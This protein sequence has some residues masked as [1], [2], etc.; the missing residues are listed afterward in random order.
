MLVWAWPSVTIKCTEASNTEKLPYKNLTRFLSVVSGGWVIS[1][2]IWNNKHFLPLKWQSHAGHWYE[3]KCT[4]CWNCMHPRNLFIVL[5]PPA[6]GFRTLTGSVKSALDL[7]SPHFSRVCQ[8]QDALKSP[9]SRDFSNK[10]LREASHHH[11]HTI[12]STLSTVNNEYTI[13]LEWRIITNRRSHITTVLA[14]I[15]QK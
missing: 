3:Q 12:Q 10:S 14:M 7:F 4:F 15:N 13:G 8:T 11:H 6:S 2:Y 1:K 5:W 9:F